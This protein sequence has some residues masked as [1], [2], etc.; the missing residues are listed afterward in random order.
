MSTF[1]EIIEA[2]EENNRINT[3]EWRDWE[4][5]RDITFAYGTIE[6]DYGD[7]G[8]E[9]LGALIRDNGEGVEYYIHAIDCLEKECPHFQGNP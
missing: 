6:G 1:L 8:L 7:I 2:V 5:P 4:D 3:A 9:F